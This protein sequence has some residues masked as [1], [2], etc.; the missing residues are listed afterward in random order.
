MKLDSAACQ[1][2]ASHFLTTVTGQ[3]S[4]AGEVLNFGRDLE[5][6]IAQPYN[7]K[8]SE[9]KGRRFV[10]VNTSV[11]NGLDIVTYKQYDVAGEFVL[12][13]DMAN[14]FPRIEIKGAQFSMGFADY[15]A[16][17]GYS[18]SDWRKAQATGLPLDAMKATATRDAFERLVERN[19]CLGDS[20]KNLTGM[21]NAPNV[22][23]LTVGSS[24]ELSGKVWHPSGGG[25]TAT[26]LEVFNDMTAMFKKI[27]EGT[28]EV[29]TP[30]SV[31]FPLKLYTYLTTTLFQ[32]TYNTDSIM[33]AILRTQKWITNVDCWTRLDSAGADGKGRV[34]VYKKDPMVLELF[35]S[36]D[37]ETFPPQVKGL[38]WSVMCHGKVGGVQ[39]RYP[40]AMVY[41]DGLGGTVS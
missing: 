30:D 40:K 3:R 17:Y 37:Y 22:P 16:S 13:E 11:N 5:H 36:Q 23:V 35:I 6:V 29:H 7:V 8:Y 34:V 1:S 24:T 41:V 18:L 28:L 21:A 19:A 32:P 10:P 4:D 9:T 31:I 20:A 33:D 38:E 15:G 12:I 14:D 39:V 27:Y 25:T 26:P 2:F